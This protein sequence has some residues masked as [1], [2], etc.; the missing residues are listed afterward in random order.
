MKANL[1]RTQILYDASDGRVLSMLRHA[2]DAA[3]PHGLVAF[4]RPQAGQ[5]VIELDIPAEFEDLSLGHLHNVIR[6][7]VSAD[8][9]RI[10]AISN[11]N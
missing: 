1:M 3:E 7:D 5:D 4:L 8:T 10:V 6:I 11:S 2:Q 9:P